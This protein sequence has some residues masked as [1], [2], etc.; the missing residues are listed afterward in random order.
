VAHKWVYHVNACDWRGKF[1]NAMWYYCA[2]CDKWI[3]GS[4]N[5]TPDVKFTLHW[6]LHGKVAIG[7]AWDQTYSCEELQIM[8]VQGA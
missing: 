8:R 1:A 5:A 4:Y 2:K 6:W 7:S 3:D